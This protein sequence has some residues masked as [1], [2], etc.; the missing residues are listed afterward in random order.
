MSTP[1]ESLNWVGT[2][3]ESLSKVGMSAESLSKV[4]TSAESLNWSLVTHSDV[5]VLMWQQSVGR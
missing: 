3:A 1:A 2:S 4:G 5:L